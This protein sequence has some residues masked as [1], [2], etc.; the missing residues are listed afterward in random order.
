MV[1]FRPLKDPHCTL[2]SSIFLKSLIQ[3][4][5]EIASYLICKDDRYLAY[6]WTADPF[7]R[8]L[9]PHFY[10]NGKWS[11]GD[12]SSWTI[13]KCAG[14]WY[15]KLEWNP[16][17][18]I[19]KGGRILRGKELSWKRQIQIAKIIGKLVFQLIFH[20]LLLDREK[21][22]ARDC[23]HLRPCLLDHRSSRLQWLHQDLLTGAENFCTLKYF[24]CI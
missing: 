6:F 16:K 22:C 13:K 20:K 23:L 1:T 9:S 21:N 19:I 12:K 7:H 10:G 17:L 5:G 15:F 3:R 2:R 14:S 4:D 8:G 24:H 11:W 18:S